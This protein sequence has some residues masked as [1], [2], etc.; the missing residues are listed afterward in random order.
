M[1]ISPSDHIHL[2]RATK[3]IAYLIEDESEELR[4]KET[5]ISNYSEQLGE[6]ENNSIQL[7]WSGCG[8]VEADFCTHCSHPLCCC[9]LAC[10]WRSGCCLWW[11]WWPC[12]S[13]AFPA[14]QLCWG[15]LRRQRPS[16]SRWII[17]ASLP[18]TITRIIVH[19][20][21]NDTA[22]LELE[23]TKL[24]FRLL[25]GFWRKSAFISGPSPTVG[26]L[27]LSNWL[28]YSCREHSVGFIDNFNVFW[29]NQTLFKLDGIHP[30]HM[31]Y[32]P[33]MCCM[34]LSMNNW[35]NRSSER[36]IS[37]T[38][39]TKIDDCS[40]C[41]PCCFPLQSFQATPQT[42]RGIQTVKMAPEIPFIFPYWYTHTDSPLLTLEVVGWLFKICDRLLAPHRR[43]VRRF[44][45]LLLIGLFND[46]SP[47]KDL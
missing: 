11:G 20:G 13:A 21:T 46:P 14:P 8:L 17:L 30:N 22:H 2:N 40:S 33:L 15:V 9:F 47:T 26:L 35:L 5:L 18:T 29:H 44:Q 45:L 37:D 19:V 10:D 28:Q 16:G 24:N 25:W 34:L 4:K 27:S 12:S 36:P 3:R 1:V 23:L 41:A 32:L 6:K 38:S 31:V 42:I 43:P 39:H 7:L